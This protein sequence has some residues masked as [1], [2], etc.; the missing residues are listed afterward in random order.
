MK[1]IKITVEKHTI[2][3]AAIVI[4]CFFVAY[5]SIR[6]IQ[7]DAWE[8]GYIAGYEAHAEEEECLNQE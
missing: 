8:K 7:S 4:V 6:D 3:C 5:S 1:D 2:I